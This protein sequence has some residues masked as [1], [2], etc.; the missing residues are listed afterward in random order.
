MISA[1]VTGLEFTVLFFAVIRALFSIINP[2]IQHGLYSLFIILPLSVF[3]LHQ[4]DAK[5]DGLDD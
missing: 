4:V 3:L 1:V 2:K 5:E